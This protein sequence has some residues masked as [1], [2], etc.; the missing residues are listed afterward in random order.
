MYIV[1]VLMSTYNGEKY[2]EA[3]LE[4]IITQEGAT[5]IILIRDDGSSDG[6]HKILKR[7]EA[8]GIQWYQGHNIGAWKSF[9]EL[10]QNA[11]KHVDL[12]NIDYIA[13]A[14]QDDI[15]DKDKLY[16]ASDGLDKNHGASLYCCALK[17]FCESNTDKHT[18]IIPKVYG[19]LESLIRNKM[20]GCTMVF[21]KEL[22]AVV[23]QYQPFRMVMH[24]AWIVQVCRVLNRRIIIDSKPHIRY[25]LHD[26]NTC[27][28]AITIR[29]KANTHI[30]RVL[31]DSYSSASVAAHELLA[32]YESNMTDEYAEILKIVDKS[33]K[34]S[35]R[36]L[37]L[38]K[39]GMK[40][41][42][43]NRYRR[44]VFIM[45]VIAGKV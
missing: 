23:N 21:T 20:A 40:E 16:T 42:F 9:M 14:D 38:L 4:S 33:R 32:G 18:V 31:G 7:Y 25:R 13:L 43:S 30:R 22:L 27:G 11:E 26:N 17:T 6:T 8:R 19:L 34:V 36:K 37:R 44:T 45:E 5:P 39:L 10:L 1:L 28:A 3:Q 2:L 29:Q 35:G 24:D 15:W 41:R 12:E